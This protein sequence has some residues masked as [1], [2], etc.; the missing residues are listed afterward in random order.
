MSASKGGFVYSLKK[1]L[2]LLLTMLVFREASTKPR[3]RMGGAALPA[4][5]VCRTPSCLAINQR[6]STGQPGHRSRRLP[7]RLEHGL[8]SIAVFSS[9]SQRLPPAPHSMPESFTL[10]LLPQNYSAATLWIALHCIA[11]AFQDEISNRHLHRQLAGVMPFRSCG[12]PPGASVFFVRDMASGSERT[13]NLRAAPSGGR[14][15]RSRKEAVKS[16]P[17]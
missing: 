14:R 1:A 12:F 13:A 15:L 9:P 4:D 8:G 10:A 6:A 11:N 3:T 5:V 7:T 16:N 2:L 17:P